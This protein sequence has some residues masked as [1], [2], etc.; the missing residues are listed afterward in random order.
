MRVLFVGNDAISYEWARKKVKNINLRV[1]GDGT[2]FVSSPH[3][4]PL[5][6]IEAFLREKADLIFR[7]KEN[8]AQKAERETLPALSAGDV[9]CLFGEPLTLVFS[10]NFREEMA[11]KEGEMR[12]KW[13]SNDPK[14]REKLRKYAE[15]RLLSLL[16]TLISR[17]LPLF[18]G[19]KNPEV[20]LRAM[21]KTWGNCRPKSG[22]LT[23]NSRLASYPV[24]CIE[25]IVMHELSHFLV[26][27]HSPRFYEELARRMPDWKE[28]KALLDQ[29]RIRPFF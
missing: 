29:S 13:G 16:L 10:E 26:P 18:C 19:V 9:I 5:S 25:Y 7:A 3:A 6:V 28:R 24:S 20:R 21:R 15:K 14:T 2:V 4:V 27:D 1:R 8:V 23:F 12:V 17:A 11:S 22:V